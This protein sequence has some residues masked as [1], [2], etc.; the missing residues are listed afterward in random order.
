MMIE[1]CTTDDGMTFTNKKDYMEYLKGKFGITD[2][3]EN[4]VRARKAA[5]KEEAKKSEEE[6]L[7]KFVQ[8]V[9][10][11]PIPTKYGDLIQVSINTE[12]FNKYNVPTNKGYVNF[13]IKCSKK[14]NYYAEKYNW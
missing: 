3:R 11:N 6:K 12:M 9:Y 7:R 1:T 8:G 4:E 2:E 10:V 13:V 14:G 5:E